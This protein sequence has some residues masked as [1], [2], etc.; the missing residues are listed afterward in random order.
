MRWELHAHYSRWSE[1]QV[2]QVAHDRN[3]NPATRSQLLAALTGGPL[4][5]L[6]RSEHKVLIS[7]EAFATQVIGRGLA[8]AHEL[9]LEGPGPEALSALIPYSLLVRL[10][11]TLRKP[12]ISKDDEV[13]SVVENAVR[14]ERV[15][16]LPMVGATAWKGSLRS[17]AIADF[18]RW[19]RKGAPE[20]TQATALVR[21]AQL[22]RLF[23]NEKE[24]TENFLNRV[25][26]KATG[27]E[28]EDVAQ[29]FQRYLEQIGYVAKRVEGRQ[30]RLFFFPT[31]LDKVGLEVI[32]PHSRTRRVGKNPIVMEC[33]RK[34]ASG[35][36]HLLYVPFDRVGEEERQTAEEAGTDIETVAK[37]LRDM[38]TELG[39]GAKT[40]SGYGVAE[41]A[42]ADGFLHGRTA[43]GQLDQPYVSF[44]TISQAARQLAVSL[45]EA[46]GA[47]Q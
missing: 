38:F 39:F 43:A 17:A 4:Q 15:F 1:A 22:V 9:G 41:T 19:C 18:C 7:S 34:G 16:R 5:E 40:S 30:G 10:R 29:R 31:F 23:G 32:N 42:V 11:F 36:F 3:L 6:A 21:R 37:S 45:R 26:A 24:Q 13:F 47:R 14:K 12:Y 8:A 25:L 27:A 2:T 46:G 28:E 33:A 35:R 20:V 44:E